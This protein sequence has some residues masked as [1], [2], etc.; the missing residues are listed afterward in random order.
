MRSNV[1]KASG[2][3]LDRSAG[4]A[5]RPYPKQVCAGGPWTRASLLERRIVVSCVVGASTARHAGPGQLR[6][7]PSC[8][9]MGFTQVHRRLS[10]FSERALED[11]DLGKCA[12]NVLTG[13]GLVR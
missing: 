5:G 10:N 3:R 8:L 1:L 11:V 6:K 7:F 13:R 9:G 12:R 4:C 2:L